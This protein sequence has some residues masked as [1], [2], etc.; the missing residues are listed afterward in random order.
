MTTQALFREDAYLTQC[1]AV[2]LAVGDDGIRLDRTVFYPLGGGQAGDT[3]TLTLPDGSTIAIA[4]TR[5]AR[6]DGAT[7]D[8]AV[9]V[10]AP[11]Q[12]ASV[13]ALAPGTRVVAEIDWLRR[14]RHMRLHTAAHLMC[15]VFALRGGRL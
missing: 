4:D 15:A 3:G 11:G 7:P 10:P 5:K 8:D 13:A 9:H 14:Y 1:D 6:F 12:E 2:V